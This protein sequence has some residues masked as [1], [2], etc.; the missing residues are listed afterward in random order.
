MSILTMQLNTPDQR[1]EIRQKQITLEQDVF[2]I[3]RTKAESEFK[4]DLSVRV[5]MDA[6]AGKVK[7]CT[8]SPPTTKRLA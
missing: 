3:I 2:S 8:T 1:M 4:G 7:I 6:L 5:G